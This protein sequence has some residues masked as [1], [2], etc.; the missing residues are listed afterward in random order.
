MS[1]PIAE[2][3]PRRS[4]AA[5]AGRFIRSDCSS[6]AAWTARPSPRSPAPRC[7]HGGASSSPSVRRCRRTGREIRSIRAH[8]RKPAHATCRISTCAMSRAR[9]RVISTGWKP[10]SCAPICLPASIAWRTMPCIALWPRPARGSSWTGMAAIIRS[11][12]HRAAGSRT[13]SSG[14]GCAASGGSCWACARRRNLSVWTILR[15]EVIAS[16]AP[17]WIARLRDRRRGHALNHEAVFPLTPAFER[18]V[19]MQGGHRQA[20]K[21]VFGGKTYRTSRLAALNQQQGQEAS[22]GRPGAAAYGLEYAQPFHDKRVIEFA[23]A[24]PSSL[25][26]RD[27]LDRYL[28]RRAL[29]DLLPPEILQ[30]PRK[31]RDD[32]IP[33]LAA[34]VGRERPQ[35]LAEIARMEASPA[36]ARHFQLRED[37]RHAAAAGWPRRRIARHAVC[38]RRIRPHAGPLHRMV[39]TRQSGS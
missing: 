38:A 3:S 9:T 12:R 2:F 8:G 17:E 20:L 33:D 14:A 23:L 16:F 39:R 11:T 4:L 1:R 19:E 5:S 7:G 25:L 21:L 18:L 22:S 32:R 34:V 6:A 29:A 10:L 36:A 13:G 35:L 26:L 31:G 37:A 27:G 15:A 24:I 30:R 28:G